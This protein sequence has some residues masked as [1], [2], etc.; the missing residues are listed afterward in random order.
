MRKK[1]LTIFAIIG[2]VLLFFSLYLNAIV[3]FQAFINNVKA[4]TANATIQNMVLVAQKEGKLVF[5][6]QDPKTNKPVS[7]T[8]I[9]QSN[10]EIKK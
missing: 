4:Q 5:N 2:L 8:L 1:L 9:V 6:G 10:P 7:L 3:L